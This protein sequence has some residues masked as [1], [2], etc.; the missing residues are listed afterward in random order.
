MLTTDPQS[1]AFLESDAKMY[2]SRNY[3][4]KETTFN[5]QYSHQL[6]VAISKMQGLTNALRVCEL[7]TYYII[8]LLNISPRLHRGRP[9]TS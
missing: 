4:L 9:K 1:I 7:D 3:F 8:F 6:S 2:D 5:Y